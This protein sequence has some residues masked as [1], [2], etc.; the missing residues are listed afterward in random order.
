MTKAWDIND[1]TADPDDQHDTSK[2]SST[3]AREVDDDATEV[4]DDRGLN[5]AGS[6]PAS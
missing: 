6:G 3:P 2:S 4:S 5:Q 1:N